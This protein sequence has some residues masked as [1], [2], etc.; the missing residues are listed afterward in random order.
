MPCTKL[1]SRPPAWPPLPQ[2]LASSRLGAA[3]CRAGPLW[4]EA[5]PRHRLATP[6]ATGLLRL[7]GRASGARKPGKPGLAS[8]VCRRRCRRLVAIGAVR[9][10]TS[11]ERVHSQLRKRGEPPR[12][13]G[14]AADSKAKGPIERRQLA[15]LAL[16]TVCPL[17]SR[18]SPHVL[19]R[20][21]VRCCALLATR[22]RRH[23]AEEVCH[24]LLAAVKAR[25][26]E[27]IGREVTHAPQQSA[28][29]VARSAHAAPPDSPGLNSALPRPHSLA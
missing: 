9:L 24:R 4:C 6:L 28:A 22:L 12:V 25:A 1:G 20:L 7:L 2:L 10:A 3:L 16:A 11:H 29:S 13:V 27:V 8:L 23:A 18:Y 17:Y 14:S 15:W 5:R 26:Q 19:C 21:C